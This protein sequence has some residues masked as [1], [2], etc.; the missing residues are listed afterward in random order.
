MIILTKRIKRKIELRERKKNGELTTKKA[1]KIRKKEYRKKELHERAARARNKNTNHLE[2]AKRVNLR[3][4]V[5]K[6][7]DNG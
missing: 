2:N 3:K 7:D 4:I 6:G 1:D 5:D